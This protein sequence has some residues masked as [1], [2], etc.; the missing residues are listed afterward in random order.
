MHLQYDMN[1]YIFMTENICV[2]RLGGSK[3]AQRKTSIDWTFSSIVH[4]EGTTSDV[5]APS[6]WKIFG[7]QNGNTTVFVS[8]KVAKY[9]SK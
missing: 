6:P 7:C 8:F 9:A 2:D 4:T 5:I 3:R 1:I